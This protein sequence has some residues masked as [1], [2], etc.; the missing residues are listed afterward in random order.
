VQ[1]GPAIA[2]GKLLIGSFTDQLQR[3]GDEWKIAKRSGSIEVKFLAS[4]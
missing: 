3:E 1:S 2:D 4:D